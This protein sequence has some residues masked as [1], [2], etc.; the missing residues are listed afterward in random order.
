MK[1]PAHYSPRVFL[2]EH[3]E[4]G[5]HMSRTSMLQQQLQLLVKALLARSP[6]YVWRVPLW[7]ARPAWPARAAQAA[8]W[9]RLAEAW[10]VIWR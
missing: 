7:K 6:A 4:R 2:P 1:C 5:R 3:D 8:D 10:R 9:P